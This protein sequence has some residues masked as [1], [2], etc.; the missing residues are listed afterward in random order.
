MPKR[1][2]VIR[3]LMGNMVHEDVIREVGEAL[4]KNNDAVI[5]NADVQVFEIYDEDIFQVVTTKRR[6]TTKEDVLRIP[7][8]K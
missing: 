1:L 3:D 5:V 2:F 6:L 8:V 4:Q 7:G